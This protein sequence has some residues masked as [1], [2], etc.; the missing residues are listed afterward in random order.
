MKFIGLIHPKPLPRG[1]V[2]VSPD[3]A[4]SWL[5]LPWFHDWPPL[6]FHHPDSP[7]RRIEAYSIV[8]GIVAGKPYAYV[9]PI[10]IT[11]SEHEGILRF[12]QN[13]PGASYRDCVRMI[14]E[15]ARNDS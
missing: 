1:S 13:H 15:G 5:T 11:R 9:I 4:A 2:G 6:S 14:A 10:G 7:R 8:S 3:R 12:W